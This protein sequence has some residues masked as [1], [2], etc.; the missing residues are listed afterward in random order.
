ML[1]N[2]HILSN[3]VESPSENVRPSQTFTKKDLDDL[4]SRMMAALLKKIDE[5]NQKMLKLIL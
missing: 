1:C 2:F 4:E 5:E 3:S